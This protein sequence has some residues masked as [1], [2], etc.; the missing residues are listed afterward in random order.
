ML[1]YFGSY[2][3]YKLDA[4]YAPIMNELNMRLILNLIDY[5]KKAS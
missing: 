3:G 1:V 2:R 5:L 4:Y